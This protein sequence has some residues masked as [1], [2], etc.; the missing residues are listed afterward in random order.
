MIGRDFVKFKVSKGKT[1]RLITPQA[2]MIKTLVDKLFQIWKKE[3]ELMNVH[4][5][6]SNA[7]I[8]LFGEYFE[9]DGEADSYNFEDEDEEEKIIEPS[10][11]PK[12]ATRNFFGDLD[13]TVLSPDSMERLIQENG[14]EKTYSRIP[15]NQRN[16]L[17]DLLNNIDT[18]AFDA[19]NFTRLG[20]ATQGV[21]FKIDDY[22]QVQQKLG[23]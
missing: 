23:I 7:L 2:P 21:A 5:M 14:E 1:I 19:P 8:D 10:Y 4:G 13:M 12:R 17:N 16:W 11:V 20:D 9:Q 22:D 3:T 6:N 18:Q 15:R